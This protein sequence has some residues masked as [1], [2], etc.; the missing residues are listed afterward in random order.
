MS[1]FLTAELEA[2]GYELAF[3]T[4]LG[5]KAIRLTQPGGYLVKPSPEQA[6][7]MRAALERRLLKPKKRGSGVPS[8]DLR[9]RVD[10]SEVYMP[11]VYKKAIPVALALLLAGYGLGKVL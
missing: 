10:L 7:K 3:N 5:G 9:T 11:V 4:L 2:R 1:N 8:T 6:R